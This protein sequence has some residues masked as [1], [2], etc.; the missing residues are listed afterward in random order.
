M[1]DFQTTAH[2]LSGGHDTANRIAARDITNEESVAEVSVGPAAT[3]FC[4]KARARR[5]EQVQIGF[6]TSRRVKPAETFEPLSC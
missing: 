6:H 4:M 5:L 2:C 1:R 3:N